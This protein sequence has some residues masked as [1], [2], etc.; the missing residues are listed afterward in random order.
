VKICAAAGNR[1]YQVLK[2]EENELFKNTYFSDLETSEAE[3]TLAGSDH[4][5]P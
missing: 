4:N 3:K 1:V 2:A 5:K